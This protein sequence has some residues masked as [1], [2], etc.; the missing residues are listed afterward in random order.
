ME[1]KIRSL[2]RSRGNSRVTSKIRETF[3]NPFKLEVQQPT[4]KFMHLRHIH[5][6]TGTEL[7]YEP[8]DTKIV[9]AL[10]PRLFDEG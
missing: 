9:W 3:I 5:F 4:R 1:Y 8:R 7:M 6:R 2:F 10:Y